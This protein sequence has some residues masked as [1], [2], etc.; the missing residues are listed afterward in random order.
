MLLNEG[1]GQPLYA[2]LTTLLKH[3]IETQQ[4][5]PGARLPSEKE[6]CDLFNVSR[7]TVRKAMN[8]LAVMGLV[9]TVP[10]KG[11][12]VS[13]PKLREPLK[14]L[15][16]F[17]EDMIK[18]GYQPYS[19]LLNSE[20]IHADDALASKMNVQPGTEIVHFIR[21]RMVNPEE[22]PIAIQTNYLLHMYCSN[23]LNINLERISL[24]DTLRNVYHLKLDRAETTIAARLATSEE[25][26]QLNLIKPAAVL[27]S[28]QVT[29]LPTGEIIEVV[30]SV[31]RSDLYQLSVVM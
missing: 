12:F 28:D 19:R 22:I 23:I 8:D 27:T 9:Y 10:G 7:I 29:Y 21:L 26:R 20:I 11:A 3:Q 30:N 6:L 31:F 5:K 16:G 18:R 4:F 15:S 25:L 13:L 2:Q 1:S 17:T 24:Y 14:P